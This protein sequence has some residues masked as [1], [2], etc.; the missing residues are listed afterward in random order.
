[1]FDGMLV[2]LILFFS[3]QPNSRFKLSKK[4]IQI[5]AYQQNFCP[6]CLDRALDACTVSCPTPT[7]NLERALNKG[8]IKSIETS[9]DGQYTIVQFIGYGNEE[10]IWVQDLLESGGEEARQKQTKEALGE[11]VVVNGHNDTTVLS[12]ETDAGP[13]K[14]N[15]DEVITLL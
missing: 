6:S 1:M 13:L 2:F 14:T 11:E 4:W 8:V 12:D 10:S 5:R 9:G 15:I 7:K 3:R